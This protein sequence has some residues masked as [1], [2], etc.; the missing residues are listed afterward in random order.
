MRAYVQSVETTSTGIERKTSSAASWRVNSSPFITGI[1]ISVRMTSTHSARSTS[2]ASRP[3]PASRHLPTSNPASASTRRTNDRIAGES[4]TSNTLNAMSYSCFQLPRFCQ[5][6]FFLCLTQ[7]NP[8]RRNLQANRTRVGSA[9][10]LGP[11]H[12]PCFPEYFSHGQVI[13]LADIKSSMGVHDL[14]AANCRD[15]QSALF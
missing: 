1:L 13:F 7:Q 15:V 10:L 11:H 12:Y 3:L 5:L 2:R 8:T 9:Y 14:R 6:P 4:S